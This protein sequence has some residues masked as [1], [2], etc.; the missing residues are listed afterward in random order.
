MN[1]PE[2]FIFLRND[3]VRGILD[4]ELIK[5]TDICIRQ[6]VPICHAV[7]PANIAHETVDWLKATKIMHPDL[8]EIIQHGYDHNCHNPEQK[9]EF[10]G[11]RDYE[12]QHKTIIEGKKLMNVHFEGLWSPVF[13]FPYGT[14]NTNTL[15]ALDMESY[16]IISSKVCFSPSILIKDKIGRWAKRDFILGKKVNYHPNKRNRYRFMEISVSVNLI[17]K[18]HNNTSADHY[19][20]VEVLEQISDA[21]MNTSIIGILFHHRFHKYHMNMIEDLIIKL[22]KNNFSFSTIMAFSH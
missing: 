15:R 11:N 17:K 4:D 9:M 14:F 22:K 8:I 7:E 20:E 2:K 1:H 21:A 19:K 5:L 13:T 12:D 3:D 6:N 16:K 18:Y 10:G